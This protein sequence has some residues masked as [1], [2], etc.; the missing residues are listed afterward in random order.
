MGLFKL[1]N[2]VQSQGI[3]LTQAAEIYGILA[4]G[5]HSSNLVGKYNVFTIDAVEKEAKRIEEQVLSIMT[6]CQGNITKTNLLAQLSSDLLNVSTVLDD[7]VRWSD[8]KP[9]V[10]PTYL[11]WKATF[12]IVE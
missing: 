1:D 6:N 5:I 4:S 8:G 2:S 11:E 7:I 12:K 9:D 10:A 3:D